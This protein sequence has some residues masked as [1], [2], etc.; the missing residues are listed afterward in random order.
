MH[1]QPPEHVRRV[2]TSKVARPTYSW[3]AS[4]RIINAQLRRVFVLQLHGVIATPATTV[5]LGTCS[6]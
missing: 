6:S 3:D 4:L 1:L 5:V 2:V